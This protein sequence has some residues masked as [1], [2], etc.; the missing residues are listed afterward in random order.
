MAD[1]TIQDLLQ[2]ALQHHQAGQW[3][4]AEAFYRQVLALQPDQPD[5][6]NLLGVLL[7]QT[8]R[9]EQ[10]VEFLRR[11][12]AVRPDHPESYGNLGN[13]L[14]SQ[15]E[16]DEAIA[17][18]RQALALRPNFVEVLSNLGNALRDKGERDE[19]IA[20]CRAA[21]ALRPDYPAAYN[22]LGNALLDKGDA[23]GAIQAFTKLVELRPDLV[24]A[25]CNLA[26]ALHVKGRLEEGR[27]HY[28]RA[29][30]M[31][32]DS[33]ETRLRFSILLVALGEM[34]QAW[35]EY[36][37]AVEQM[38]LARHPGLKPAWDGS[39]P[40][41]KTILVYA[42][43]NFG[44]TLMLARFVPVLR[45]RGAKVIL[46]CQPALVALLESLVAQRTLP[47]EAPTPTFDAY[48]TL[49]SLPR[50]LGFTLEN[51]PNQVPYVSAPADRVRK[52]AGRVP[53]DGKLNVGL[54]WAPSNKGARSHSLA[55]FAPLAGVSGVRFV[56]L[57][58]GPESSQTPPEGLELMDFTSELNDFADTAAVMKQLDL[59]ISVDTAA[60]HLAGA[61]AMPVWALITLQCNFHWLAEGEDSPW[62]PT[63]RLFRQTQV[64]NWND[65][66]RRM[67]GELQLLADKK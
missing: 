40:A 67:A 65:P 27:A 66:V 46:L 13:V 33:S 41:G 14:S 62:Y 38:A 61:L 51:L 25:H 44:D 8:G 34:R 30:E 9:K 4:E 21:L 50:G 16:W 37:I 28:L 58:K 45:Q 59:L 18:Y 32:P 48:A 15:G 7:S 19:A 26:I 47:L 53:R 49:G 29:L 1:P 10:A 39:D 2:K 5:A 3:G 36:F 52:W 22:N 55:I 35:D 31:Q 57:Q 64:S 60:V 56:S 11:S 17:A 54:V 6:L 42:D 63:A 12:V 23:S 43:G 20:A 24:D